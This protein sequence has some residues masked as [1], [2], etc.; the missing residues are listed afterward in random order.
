MLLSY[1]SLPILQVDVLENQLNLLSEWKFKAN[2][3][4]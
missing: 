4:R 3:Q 2:S 1:G